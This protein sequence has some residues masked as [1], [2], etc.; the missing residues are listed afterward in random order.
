MKRKA[1][2]AVDNRKWHQMMNNEM[3]TVKRMRTKMIEH[4]VDPKKAMSGVG[5]AFSGRSSVLN[6]SRAS[7]PSAL[8]PYQDRSPMRANARNQGL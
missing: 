7:I 3:D 2:E 6:V 8:T 5:G 4:G 1:I